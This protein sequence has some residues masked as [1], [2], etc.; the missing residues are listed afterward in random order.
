[1]TINVDAGDEAQD[2]HQNDVDLRPLT[3]FDLPNLQSVELH[4]R[5]GKAVIKHNDLGP[6]L[7]SR[8]CDLDLALLREHFSKLGLTLLGGRGR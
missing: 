3:G 5:L 4:I 8:P 7:T 2:E 6:Q 1:V